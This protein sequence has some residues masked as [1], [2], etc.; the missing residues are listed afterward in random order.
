MSNRREDLLK[1]ELLE[2]SFTS[3]YLLGHWL[4]AK[5]PERL[6]FHEPLNSYDKILSADFVEMV[7]DVE[8][9]CRD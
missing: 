8:Q 6:E 9:E 3:G 4:A 2:M 7:C 1:L 5:K